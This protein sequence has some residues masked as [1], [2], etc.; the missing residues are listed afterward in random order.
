MS[1]SPIVTDRCT[2]PTSGWPCSTPLSTIATRTPAP[3][4]PPQAHS[5]VILAGHAGDATALAL[6]AARLQAGS[7]SGSS[8]SLTG[9]GG[10]VDEHRVGCQTGALQRALEICEHLLPEL[11]VCRGQGG[12]LIDRA[13][14]GG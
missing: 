7:S 3:V 13:P 8:A 14:G 9:D 4:A 6:S 5:R 1:G 11:C 10:D 12:D 2:A